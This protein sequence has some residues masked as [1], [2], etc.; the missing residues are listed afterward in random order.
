[1]TTCLLKQHV[2]LCWETVG[3]YRSEDIQWCPGEDSNFHAPK[4]TGT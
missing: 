2:K 3:Y 1:M 4:G